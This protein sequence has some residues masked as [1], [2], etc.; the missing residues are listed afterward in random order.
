LPIQT[1]YGT[2][3]SPY[4]EINQDYYVHYEDDTVS[5]AVVADGAGSL[6]KSDEGAQIVCETIGN[7]LLDLLDEGVLEDFETTNELEAELQNALVMATRKIKALDNYKEYGCTVAVSV[8]TEKL[9]S[10]LVLGDAFAVLHKDLENHELVVN[11]KT[12]EFANITTL[13]TSKNPDIVIRSGKFNFN[14]EDEND[15]TNEY[16]DDYENVVGI[17]ISS[18]GLQFVSTDQNGAV[19]GFW[20][21][22][23][24]RILE[25]NFDLDEFFDYLNSIDRIDDDTTLVMTL[26]TE[27]IEN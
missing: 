2:I 13:I 19:S 21:T 26:L 25:N 23:I 10:V 9:W 12:S 1:V 16:F 3:K 4:H 14:A 7:Y 20:G 11:E 17:S 27:D 24:N 18:D 5:I 15:E 22:I 8:I 6:P